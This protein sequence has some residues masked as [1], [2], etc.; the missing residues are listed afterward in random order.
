MVVEVHSLSFCSSEKIIVVDV[1]H[2]FLRMVHMVYVINKFNILRKRSYQRN[3]NF[4]CG[5]K[6]YLD[7]LVNI[8]KI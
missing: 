6:I 7:H 3:S 8:Y 2:L 4:Q 1:K 5:K